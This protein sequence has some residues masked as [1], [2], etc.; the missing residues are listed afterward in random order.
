MKNI[1]VP[2]NFTPVAENSLNYA[3]RLAQTAHAKIT[4]LYVYEL[5]V[6]HDFIGLVPTAEELEA[7]FMPQLTAVKSRVLKACGDQIE[8][9][10]YCKA[11][12]VISSIHSVALERAA[13]LIV[14]GIPGVGLLTEKLIGSTAT[15]LMRKAPVPVLIIGKD[16]TFRSIK[17][18]LFATD[19]QELS[20]DGPVKLLKTFMKSFLPHLYIL[21]INSAPEPAQVTS[22]PKADLRSERMFQDVPHSY[23]SRQQEH[24]ADAINEFAEEYAIDLLAVIP[25]TH[26]LVHYLLHEATTKRI[27]FHAGIPVLAIHE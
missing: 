13:D 25:R 19:E 23:Y 11:G 17:K 8:A 20:E 12:E 4:L 14:I 2:F 15:D 1:L 22:E 7:E 16:V 27:A 24:V 9:D 10:C 5:I 21:H 26:S 18:V 3:A 6:S